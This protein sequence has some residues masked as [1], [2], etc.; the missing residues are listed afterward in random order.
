MPAVNCAG[1]ETR[2]E[3]DCV[4]PER[5]QSQRVNE[6]SNS[7]FSKAHGAPPWILLNVRALEDAI[8]LKSLTALSHR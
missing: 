1:S 6:A 2:P 3:R 7:G 8:A 4:P 5:D